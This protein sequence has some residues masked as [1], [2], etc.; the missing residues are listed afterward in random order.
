VTHAEQVKDQFPATILVRKT[1]AVGAP[2]SW[3]R[4]V[5]LTAAVSVVAAS[6]R[7]SGHAARQ[8]GTHDPVPS[9]SDSPRAHPP[10]SSARNAEAGPTAASPGCPSSTEMSTPSAVRSRRSAIDLPSRC[11]RRR[12]QQVVQQPFDARRVDL[13]RGALELD[14]ERR[15]SEKGNAVTTRFTSVSISVLRRRRTVRRA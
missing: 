13:D 9:G 12:G 14:V 8:E 6:G 5:Q 4:Q 1:G 3:S 10:C 11:V 2:R 15:S 7:G